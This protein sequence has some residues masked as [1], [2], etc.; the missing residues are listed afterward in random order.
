MAAQLN[1]TLLRNAVNNILALGPVCALT[2]PAARGDTAL[3]QRQG[4]AVAQWNTTA[5]EAYQALS[6][7]AAKL[8]AS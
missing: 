4:E 2:G 3:V 6:Q 5:G 1:T 7:L 8:A